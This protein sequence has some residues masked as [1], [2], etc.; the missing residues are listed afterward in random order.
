[1]LALENK[2]KLFRSLK[3]GQWWSGLNLPSNFLVATSLNMLCAPVTTSHVMPGLQ[4]SFL[5]HK[6]EPKFLSSIIH[7]RLFILKLDL[8]PLTSKS[9]LY[10]FFHLTF[11]FTVGQFFSLQWC[12][13][14]FS[15]YLMIFILLPWPF[16][17]RFLAA[18]S[19]ILVSVPSS[20]VF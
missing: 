7:W 8:V 11:F 12:L 3:W 5:L 1:M 6:S 14:C 16:P 13:L 18:I 2:F 20:F 17:S 15:Y 4:L 19:S 9:Y 10:H